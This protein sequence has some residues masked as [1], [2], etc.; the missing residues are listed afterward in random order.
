MSIESF[1]ILVGLILV[2]IRVWTWF[3]AGTARP[4]PW[5]SDVAY[6]IEEESAEPLCYHCLAPQK[7]IRWFC[8]ECGTAV[9]PYN[10]YDPYLGV[11]SEGQLLRTGV[12]DQLPRRALIIIGYVILPFAF[13]AIFAPIYWYFL[14]RNLSQSRTPPIESLNVQ[15]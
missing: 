15:T 8:P 14:F 6:A 10:N 11:F 2:A 3:R 7:Q 9:G 1:I 13:F 12:L 5:D 4:D